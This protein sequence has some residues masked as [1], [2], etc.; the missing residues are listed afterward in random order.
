MRQQDTLIRIILACALSCA[1]IPAMAASC[2]VLATPLAFGP[3]DA[4]ASAPRDATTVVEVQCVTGIAE[5]PTVGYAIGFVGGAG[6]RRLLS[7]AHALSFELYTDA[8]RS[9]VWGDGLSGTQVM[10]TVVTPSP[11]TPALRAHT[12][13]GRVPARQIVPRGTYVS[14][15]TVVIEY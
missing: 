13:Y 4:T 12:V 8:T 7:A 1:V 11:L 10:G 2:Q 15:V 9:H 14:T 6:G 3:Y 5:S